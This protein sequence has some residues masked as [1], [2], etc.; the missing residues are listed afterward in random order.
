MARK[1]KNALVEEIAA[2]SKAVCH[3]KIWQ[4]KILK[5]TMGLL[6][7]IIGFYVFNYESKLINKGEINYGIV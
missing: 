3:R 7:L 5:N 1:I 2:D 4:S 6:I